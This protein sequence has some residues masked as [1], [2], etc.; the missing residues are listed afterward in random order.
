MIWFGANRVDTGDLQLGALIAFLTYL[1]QILM[2]VMLA[3]YMAALVPRA[4]GQR[5][6]HPGGARH[7]VAASQPPTTRSTR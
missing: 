6:A 1:T 7:A 2:A 3:T 5:R 4:V